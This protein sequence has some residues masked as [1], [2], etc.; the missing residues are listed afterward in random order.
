MAAALREGRVLV[1]TDTDFGTSHDGMG[2]GLR[3]TRHGS[4]TGT[5]ANRA[6]R[7]SRVSS[8]ALSVSA[9]AT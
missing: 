7:P 9:H 3:R 6:K 1:T 8:V 4:S 5:G 2:H